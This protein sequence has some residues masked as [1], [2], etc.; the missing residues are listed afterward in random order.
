MASPCDNVELFVDGGLDALEAERFREH[1]VTCTA[2]EA[3]IA[4]LMHLRVLALRYHERKLARG[5]GQARMTKAPRLFRARSY[6]AW[7]S[8]LGVAALAA[9]LVVVVLKGSSGVPDEV[10]RARQP[11]LLEARSAYAHADRYRPLAQGTLG[12]EGPASK[13]TH[14][15]LARL[16]E[17][18]DY[19]GIAAAYLVWNDPSLAQQAI[20]QLDEHG[21]RS[22][23]ADNE[24]AVARLTRRD[25][26]RNDL[27]E[28]YR[29]LDGVLSRNPGH[30]QAL[31]N[32]A[33]ALRELRLTLSAARAFEQIAQLKEPGWSDEARAN[34]EKLKQSVLDRRRRWK[35]A[36]DA[37][38][39]LVTTGALPPD[40]ISKSALIL[41]LHFYD[42]VRSRTSPEQVRA[43]L[44]LAQSLDAVSGGR[45]LEQYVQRIASRDFAVRRPLAE[46]YALLWARRLAP[47]DIE[48][49]LA[50]LLQSREDDIFVGAVVLTDS[51]ARH[52]EEL[53]RRA[54]ATG[55]PWFLALAAQKLALVDASSQ[56]E[57]AEVRHRLDEALRICQA[58]RLDYRCIEIEIQLTYLLSVAGRLDEAHLHASKGWQDA[59]KV[60]EWDKQTQFIQHLAQVARLR[61]DVPLSRAYLEEALDRVRYDNDPQ[62]EQF[63][64]GNLAAL[65]HNA[66]RFDSA[67][68]HVDAMLD[69]RLPLTITGAVVLADVARVR[70][71][72]RD[73]AAMEAFRSQLTSLQGRGDLA[74]ATHALGRYTVEV[75]PPAGRKLL[76]DSIALA[77]GDRLADRSSNA[78]RALAYSYTSL[79]LEAAK[80]RDF[81]GA[82]ALFVRERGGA[83]ADKCM[84]AVTGDTERMLVVIRDSEGRMLGHYDSSRSTPFPPAR[85]DGVVP[86]EAVSALRSCP[87]VVVIARPPLVGRAGLLPA[88]IAW[89]YRTEGSDAA[90][91][92]PSGGTHLMV[93]NISLSP[94][95]AR[96]LKKPRDWKPIVISQEINVSLE[97]AEATPSAVLR[98]MEDAS[99]IDIVAHGL[100]DPASDEAFL[101]LSPDGEEDT[102]SASRLARQ[103]SLPHRPLVVLAACNA[104]HTASALY[105]ARSLPAAFIRAGARA[106]FAATVEIPDQDAPRFFAAVRA[107]IRAGAPAAVALRDERTEWL[108][109]QKNE[110][111]INWLDGILLFD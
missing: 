83:L 105:E 107:R 106:V 89:S 6:G 95:R 60:N 98:S 103:G 108:K 32:R 13:L 58:A 37:G 76:E 1:L 8:G 46:Q 35:A 92:S 88:D 41:R 20:D 24:R 28:A 82:L 49:L 25:A 70:P 84:V 87:M 99:E 26:D 15:L 85:L 11:R 42:A 65:E 90:V 69:I 56:G 44:P 73:A 91:K 59:E 4:E 79:L 77:I 29:L 27:E 12:S 97:G 31:W 67:R 33:L 96:T 66:F 53:E 93:Q 19:L 7:A 16:E 81:E 104:A 57:S 78:R 72:K 111:V 64:R 14:Q 38:K 51:V 9:V 47:A 23:D 50:A 48:H 22:D 61:N 75:D 10:W 30:R 34:A 17:R 63:L 74:L 100:I 3:T 101:V 43:L 62:K 109:N 68:Q 102:L 86:A 54:K 21:V 110:K 45:V 52:R 5:E 94:R 18:Q 2:C 39:A 71:S 36:D 55:D 40:E 80:R